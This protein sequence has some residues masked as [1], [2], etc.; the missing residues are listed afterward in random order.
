MGNI[1]QLDDLDDNR[2][3]P[4]LIKKFDSKDLGLK[5]HVKIFKID[6]DKFEKSEI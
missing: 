6:Y 1:D 4:Y 3:V 5:Y 2:M